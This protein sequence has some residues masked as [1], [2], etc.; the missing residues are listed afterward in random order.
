MRVAIDQNG[1]GMIDN[2]IEAES[3]EAAAAL[4]P[5]DTVMDAVSAGVQI[6][7]ISDRQGGYVP[8][9]D[10][11]PKYALISRVAFVRLC[12]SAGGMTPDMLVQAKAAPELA[13]LWIMLDMAQEVRAADPEVPPG[14]AEIEALG[15]LP[16]GAQAVLDAWPMA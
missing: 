9:P 11:E 4:F 5:A 8:P 2:I 3:L 15:F 16:A 1:G 12:M 10:P 7:W 13:A 6:G 14:L